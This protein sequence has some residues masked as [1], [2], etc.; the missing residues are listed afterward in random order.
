MARS[1]V[2]V[3]HPVLSSE[4]MASVCLCRLG[5]G[6]STQFSLANWDKKK[7]KIPKAPVKN[8]IPRISLTIYD[9]YLMEVFNP[10]WLLRIWK[11]DHVLGWMASETFLTLY[12]I[13]SSKALFSQSINATF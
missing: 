13:V 1:R 10:R 9:G 11:L 3:V 5:A 4:K 2:T 7:K 8:S 6:V 12:D